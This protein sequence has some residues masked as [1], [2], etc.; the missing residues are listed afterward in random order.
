MTERKS[1]PRTLESRIRRFL[2]PVSG[3]PIPQTGFSI[4]LAKARGLTVV[5]IVIAVMIFGV[6]MIPMV[7]M[8]QSGNRDTIKLKNLNIATALARD[9]IETVRA[10]PFELI[11]SG[12]ELYI[13]DEPLTGGPGPVSAPPILCDGNATGPISGFAPPGYFDPYLAKFSAKVAIEKITVDAGTTADAIGNDPSKLTKVV[14][15]V[16]WKDDTGPS[17][18]EREVALRTFISKPAMHHPAVQTAAGTPSVEMQY[19]N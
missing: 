1:I 18:P 9:L 14:V 4:P 7:T 10:H 16:L 13:Y 15:T 3:F 11:T 8:F 5:E 6:G 12:M 17:S 19:G 2:N